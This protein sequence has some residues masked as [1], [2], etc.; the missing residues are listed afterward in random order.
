MGPQCQHFAQTSVPESSAAGQDPPH[1]EPWQGSA[2][3][4]GQGRAAF[5]HAWVSIRF[6]E[7][8]V[9]PG[10]LE[11]QNHVVGQGRVVDARPCG[12]VGTGADACRG[13]GRHQGELHEAR[14]RGRMLGTPLPLTP[15]CGAPCG[16]PDRSSVEPH[17]PGQDP[18]AAGQGTLWERRQGRPAAQHSRVQAAAPGTL[19]MPRLLTDFSCGQS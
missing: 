9:R 5:A 7:P 14:G 12:V 18:E 10:L 1:G 11:K 13:A 3:G 6:V 16:R 19:P 2:A 15:R 4:S 17:A 8:R